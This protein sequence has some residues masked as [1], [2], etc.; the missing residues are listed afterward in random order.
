MRKGTVRWGV[1]GLG[2]I[3]HR[4]LK[5]FRA[6]PPI[7]TEVVAVGSRDAAKARTFAATYGIPTACGSY[8]EVLGNPAVD[9][10]YIALPNHLHGPWTLKAIAAGKHVLCEKPFAM[11][12]AEAKTMIAAAHRRGVF[13]M[14]AFMYRCHPQMAKLKALLRSRA[15]GEVR[16]IRAGFAFGGINESNVRMRNPEGGGGLMDVGCYPVSFMRFVTGEEPVDVKATAVIGKKS[17]VDHWAAGVLKFPSGA[18]GYFDCGMMVN[19]DWSATI[20]GTKGRVRLPSPW[21]PEEREAELE[22]TLYSDWKTESRLVKSKHYF[23][24]EAETVARCI[25]TGRRESREMSLGDTLG[26]MKALDA[27]RA[28]MGLAWDPERRNRR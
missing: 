20:F 14:E 4:V 15:L 22:I 26:N 6:T 27:L 17:R 25:L 9:L 23:A 13:L 12:A 8:E 1:I 2:G 19:S 3:A 11:N 5:G 18:I 24:N 7:A 28:S 16:L 21:I 10:V